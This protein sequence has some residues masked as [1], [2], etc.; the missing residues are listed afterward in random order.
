MR[1]AFGIEL[2]DLLAVRSK[3]LDDYIDPALI[4][5]EVGILTCVEREHIRMRLTCSQLSFNRLISFELLSLL[6]VLN[7]RRAASGA[8]GANSLNI[9]GRHADKQYESATNYQ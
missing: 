4:N 6:V 1:P 9:D 7:R 2:Q 3:Q 8:S 5:Y